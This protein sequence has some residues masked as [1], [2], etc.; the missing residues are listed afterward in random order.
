MRREGDC[1][2]AYVPREPRAWSARS[3]PRQSHRPSEV[4][5]APSSTQHLPTAR[6]GPGA[7]GPCV[8]NK[9]CT[10]EK[11]LPP[12]RELMTRLH[13][14][15]RTV[16]WSSAVDP[17][18]ELV[19]TGLAHK[20]RAALSGLSGRRH[21]RWCRVRAPSSGRRSGPSEL[22]QPYVTQMY[23]LLMQQASKCECASL[24]NPL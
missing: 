5:L 17:T 9:H 6:P 15:S 19:C 22:F 13:L 3:L 20:A 7:S 4:L 2:L 11:G 8:L 1:R 10:G 18:I 23:I 12:P 21:G 24:Y 16:R 14:L